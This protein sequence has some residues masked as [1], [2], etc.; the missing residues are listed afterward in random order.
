MRRLIRVIDTFDGWCGAILMWGSGV[1]VH[2]GNFFLLAL[3]VVVLVSVI[4]GLGTVGYVL[5]SWTQ[6]G[7]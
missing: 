5:V 6:G 1:A 3:T 7:L 2:L 4:L